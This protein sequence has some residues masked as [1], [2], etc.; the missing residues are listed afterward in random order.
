[1]TGLSVYR[2]VSSSTRCAMSGII[3]FSIGLI[4]VLFGVCSMAAVLKNPDK[5]NK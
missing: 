5:S 1:M 3:Y 4:G 2:V